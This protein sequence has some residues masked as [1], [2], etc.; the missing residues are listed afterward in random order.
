MTK[1][2]KNQTRFLAILAG[3]VMCQTACGETLVRTQAEYAAAVENAA[4]GDTI[5]LANGEWRDF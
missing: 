5:V 1:A 4:P 3:I 2:I